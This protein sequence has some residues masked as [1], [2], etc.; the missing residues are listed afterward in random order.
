M[1]ATDLDGREFQDRIVLRAFPAMKR[2]E[3]LAKAQDGARLHRERVVAEIRFVFC[4]TLFQNAKKRRPLLL[5]SRRLDCN[6]R[7]FLPIKT[8]KSVEWIVRYLEN[9]VGFWN[10]L[11]LGIYFG[12][13]DCGHG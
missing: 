9:W 12:F 1:A 6:L 4:R 13:L 2:L 3:D 11:W 5:T 8:I 10:L 7:R